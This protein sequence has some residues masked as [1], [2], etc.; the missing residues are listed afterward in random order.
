[1]DIGKRIRE[2]RE[3]YGMSA[4]VLARRTGVAPGYIYQLEHDLRTPSV[5]MLEKIAKELRTEPA[6]FLR[7][8]ALLGKDRAPETG[9]AAPEELEELLYKEDYAGDP[10]GAVSRAQAAAHEARQDYLPRGMRIVMSIENE[11]VEVRAVAPST[12]AT[13]HDPWDRIAGSALTS[14]TNKNKGERK[15]DKNT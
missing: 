1:M 8:P 10:E 14:W 5:A 9:L 2:T 15:V 7:E 3:E 13:Q 12:P 4:A 11:T 6:E